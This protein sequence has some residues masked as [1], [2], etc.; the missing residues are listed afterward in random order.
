[1]YK[2][3]AG[4]TFERVARKVYGDGDEAGRIARSNP[5]VAEPMPA[6]VTLAI[7]AVPGAPVDRASQQPAADPDAVSVAID[8]AR[9]R[10][11]ESVRVTRSVDS[12]DTI[13]LGAPFDPNA[14]GFRDTFRP[15]SYRPIT[16]AIGGAP[17][18]VGTMVDV[19]PNL[20]NTRNV[21][22]SGYATPGVLQDCTAPA[23]AY[24]LEFEG[25]DLRAIA[26]KLCEPFGVSVVF[27]A[28]AGAAFDS[29]ALEPGSKIL[30][31][32]HDL[33]KQRGLIVGSTERG[34]LRFWRAVRPGSPVA[35]LREGA[36]PV[37]AVTPTFA[38]Q[39]Y[40]SHVT[41]IEPPDVGSDGAQF[42]TRNPAL[43][44]VLRPFAFTVADGE[45][46]EATQAK[47]GRM[48][49]GAA[50]Y[51]VDVATWRDPAGELWRPN[52][53][54]T[55]EAPSAMI[56]SE[57]EFLIRSVTFNVDS[58]SRDAVLQLVIPQA[59]R[60]EMPGALPWD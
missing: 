20:S 55:L 6:G 38:P 57:Y 27:E 52:T 30:P 42:T 3:D 56:Y 43:A 50:A 53:T 41:G 17:V 58:D 5:G 1:M 33:A 24:P 36:A 11:W 16:V 45:V 40:Y 19:K 4:D 54:I 39:E 44:G 60:G 34:A 51:S 18:F 23:S 48:F 7:P 31:F 28:P 13:G 32:L 59:F 25:L 8:G 37:M 2:T 46:A 12:I 21:S 47:A 26:S 15:F 29:V 35:R 10:F 9:F 22:V 49:A 14:P